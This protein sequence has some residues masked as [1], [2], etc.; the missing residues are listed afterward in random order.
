M[1]KHDMIGEN[2]VRLLQD[3]LLKHGVSLNNGRDLAR[4]VQSR[5]EYL[6]EMSYLP[7]F[8]DAVETVRDD[9]LTRILL[10]LMGLSDEAGYELRGVILG[11]LV[12]GA[13][14]YG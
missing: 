3:M 10:R 5:V 2:I 8:M 6:G 4:H 7:G 11:A 14:C 12:V 1:S 9:I 13:R